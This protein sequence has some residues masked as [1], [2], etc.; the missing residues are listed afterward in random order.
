[1]SP[2]LK[3]RPQGSFGR[4]LDVRFESIMRFVLGV[5][6]EATQKTHRWN[7]HH[8]KEGQVAH[9][10]ANWMVGHSG[11]PHARKL[12]PVTILAG[13]L[14]HATRFGGWQRYLVLAPQDPDAGLWYIGWRWKGG[15]GVS[16]ISVATP[17]RVLIG[18]GP[19]EWFAI[20]A[21]D[22]HQIPLNKIGEGKIGESGQFSDLPLF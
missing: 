2:T 12:P 18:P 20:K 22:D 13:A 11:D 16:R 9:L 1:M 7:N 10:F 8:L 5:P 14:S 15:A 6:I 3:V 4:W 19:T 21:S 17:V